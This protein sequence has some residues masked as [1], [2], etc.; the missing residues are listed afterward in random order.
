MLQEAA[1]LGI[2]VLAHCENGRVIELL[3]Q[4]AVARGELGLA[5]L[6][7]TRPIELEAECVHRFL[8]LAE[9]AG[10]TA[11]VVHV[12]GA[13]VVDEIAAA[14]GARQAVY[15][16]VCPHH[17]LFDVADHS[18]PDGIRYV[19]TPPLRTAEDR[20]VLARAL[21]DGGLDTLASDHCHYTL[22]QKIAVAGDFRDVP[23]GLP[24]IAARLPLGFGITADGEP[25][26][27]ERLVEVAC[28]APARIFGLPGKGVD[29]ARAPTPT[30]SC[31]IPRG[32]RRSRSSR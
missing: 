19:F 2:V 22:E 30:S 16:E 11:Y 9:L 5:S 23:T 20:V 31:G 4:Q 1:E 7:A 29:R 25:L 17:L 32:P 6:P 10:A 27:I 8:V 21:R 3:T 12:T 15:G 28:A 26:P 13:S 24:G 18:G 14:R